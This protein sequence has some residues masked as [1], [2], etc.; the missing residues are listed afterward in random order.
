MKENIE[1]REMI[2]Y[3]QN[4]CE[5]LVTCTRNSHTINVFS[6]LVLKKLSIV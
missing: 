4:Q 2:F 1:K 3:V 6:N 5:Q